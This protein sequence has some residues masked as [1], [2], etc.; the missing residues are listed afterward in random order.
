MSEDHSISYGDDRMRL[1]DAERQQVVDA[2]SRHTADG[3]L[4]MDEFEQRSEQA[5]AARTRGDLRG[6]LDD[7]PTAPGADGPATLWAGAPPAPPTP[8]PTMLRPTPGPTMP[9]SRG[10]GSRMQGSVPPGPTP[11]WGGPP[12]APLP[13]WRLERLRGVL[14]LS[15]MLIA[16]WLLS[17]AGYFWPMWVI[18]PVGIGVLCG[19]GHHGCARRGVGPTPPGVS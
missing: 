2:L 5:L 4:S 11:A 14:A 8:G 16:I 13:R 17:G 9:G 6:L 12:P 19:G 3:R 1:S 18:V 10:P 15:V 7:L